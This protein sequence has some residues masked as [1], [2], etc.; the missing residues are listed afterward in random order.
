VDLADVFAHLYQ[1]DSDTLALVSREIS[2]MISERQKEDKT[3]TKSAEQPGV[4][5]T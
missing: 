1:I 5:G 3:E 2:R 4:Y